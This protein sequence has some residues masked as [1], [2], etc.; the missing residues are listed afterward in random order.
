VRVDRQAEETGVA[1]RPHHGGRKLVGRVEAADFLLRA[2]LSE[3]T[4]RRL[5]D[6]R[7]LVGEIEID[8]VDIPDTVDYLPVDR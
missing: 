4:P 5:L 1:E 3:D 8:H 6:H 2:H 7:L